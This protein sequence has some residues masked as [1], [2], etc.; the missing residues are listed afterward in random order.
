MTV[1]TIVGRPAL[2]VIDMQEDFVSRFPQGQ[3][4]ITPINALIAAF[5]A[6]DLPLIL[7][8]EM[9][10]P[11]GIDG[12]LESDPHYAVP[13]H[14]VIGTPGAAIVAQLVLRPDDPIIDKRRYN[15]FLGTEL[16]LLL[17]TLR[18][19][20]LVVTGMDSASACTGQPARPSSTTTTCGCPRIAWPARGRRGT[21]RR[22]CSCVTSSAAGRR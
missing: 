10:R 16:A 12:G 2:L 20:T 15:C 5:R 17:H 1:E 13:P 19:Q 3:A 9:H 8:R 22:C 6:R 7:T 11:G 4:I 18:V 21:R 14:T